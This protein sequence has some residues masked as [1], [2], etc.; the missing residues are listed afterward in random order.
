MES[1]EKVLTLFRKNK[2]RENF[3][4]KAIGRRNKLSREEKYFLSITFSSLKV[5]YFPGLISNVNYLSK[6]LKAFD[7][8]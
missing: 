4:R 1:L 7:I 6:R 5:S 3:L 8:L 2:G